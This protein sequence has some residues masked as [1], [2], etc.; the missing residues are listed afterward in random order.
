MMHA[1]SGAIV[2]ILGQLSS[3]YFLV[4]LPIIYLNKITEY[5]YIMSHDKAYIIKN[6]FKPI[7]YEKID[8]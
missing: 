7:S 1:F 6:N 4:I 3:V 2:Y 5:K 8:Y